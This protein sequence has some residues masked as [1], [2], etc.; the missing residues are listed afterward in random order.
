[1]TDII[2][3]MDKRTANRLH[4][5]MEN[6]LQAL[7]EKHG[8]TIRQKGGSISRT[9]GV[10]KFEVA[11]KETK[12]GEIGGIAA[13]A[14]RQIATVFGMKAEDLGR[15]FVAHG[16]KHKIVGCKTSR[17]SKPILTKAE[18][19]RDYVWPAETVRLYLNRAA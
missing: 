9:G 2:T 6:D 5:A 4:S 1:M 17:T 12:S 16:I 10:F 18:N 3:A 14:F 15:E 8:L 11:I 13:D 7:A 19:G